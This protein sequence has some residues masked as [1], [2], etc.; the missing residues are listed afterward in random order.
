[1]Q[2]RFYNMI[3]PCEE[4]IRRKHSVKHVSLGTLSEPKVP[5]HRSRQQC[6]RTTR[7]VPVW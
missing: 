2:T 6:R 1:M 7:I 4:N 5:Y 3:L